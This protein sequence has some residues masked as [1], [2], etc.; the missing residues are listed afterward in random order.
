MQHGHQLEHRPIAGLVPYE[1]NARTHSKK[2]VRQ[3]AGSIERFGFTNPLL[4]TPNGRIVAG[5][6]RV[7]AAKLLGFTEVPTLVLANL[8]D[9]ERRAYILADNKLAANAG[10]D[11]EILAIELQF[12]SEVHFDLEVTGFSIAEIDFALDGAR[13]SDPERKEP[14]PEDEIIPRQPHAVSQLGDVWQL[15]RHF[16]VC[17]DARQQSAYDAVTCGAPIDLV[18]ADPPY[19]CPINGHL[20]GKGKVK[21]R[22]FAMASG[23]M[24]EA[25]FV[26][27]LRQTL[28]LAAAT[29]RDGAIAFICMD[30]RGME[31]L[32]VA[33]RDAFTEL[34]QLCV[35]NKSRGGM[36]TF[37]RSKHELVFAFKI[38]TAKH[39]NSFGLGET[40]RYRTNVWDYSNIPIAQPDSSQHPTPKPVAMVA[41]AIRDCTKRGGLVLDNFG[42][43]G[44]TLIAAETCGRSARLIEFD[45][46]YCDCIIRRFEKFTGKRAI[47]MGGQATFE[48]VEELRLEA[49]KGSRQ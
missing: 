5:H 41:D 25:E 49:A 21:H 28:S 37:Y 10:W 19:N 18:F 22:E 38:G 27:F 35:W 40:G 32:L 15:G 2:Q 47:L 48:E 4:I 45:P 3:I 33:G 1:R 43:S 24:T 7:Q 46:L 30:W 16:L 29:C 26:S 34:K 36:G 12:L 9:A 6:G 17:G 14:L 31:S 23:E 20:S 13:D 42:G 8:D 39:V 44:T 11:S